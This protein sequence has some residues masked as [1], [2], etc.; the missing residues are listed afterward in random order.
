MPSNNTLLEIRRLLNAQ[1]MTHHS[2]NTTQSAGL[3]TANSFL[4]M[5]GPGAQFSGDQAVPN[6]WVRLTTIEFRITS[7]AGAA[8]A[9]NWYLA[10]DSAGL[11]AITPRVTSSWYVV[12]GTTGT[13]AALID[14]PYHLITGANTT[15]G[16]IYLVASVDA[17]TATLN[18]TLN[19]QSNDV[20]PTLGP[21]ED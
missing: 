9:L 3:T 4:V 2:G 6:N 1:T 5:S 15:E 10:R 19:W 8:T 12:S 11:Y 20:S 13:T 21:D 7:I 18:A 17:D 14:I 16:V